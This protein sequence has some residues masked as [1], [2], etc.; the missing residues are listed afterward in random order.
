MT[1]HINRS[2]VT[3]YLRYN[4][5]QYEREY[6]LE[7]FRDGQGTIMDLQGAKISFDL[8]LFPN[9]LSPKAQENNYFKVLVVA[10]DEDPEAPNFN[11]DEISLSFFKKAEAIREVLPENNPEFGVW[12]SVVRSRQKSDEEESG[13]KFYELFNTDFDLIE[14]CVLGKTG[15]LK[16]TWQRSVATNETFTYAIDLGTSNTFMSRCKNDSNGQ[17]DLSK[18][19]ELFKMERPMVSFMHEIPD[20][21]QYSLTRR[22]EDSIFEKAKRKIKTEFLPAIIDGTD[23]RFPIRTAL[24]GI[25]N[26]AHKPKLFDNHNI[27]FFY[28]KIMAN[29]D[30]DVHTD[31]KWDKN[32]PLLRI[33][34]RELLLIIK[35]DIL[36]RNGDLDRTNLVWFSPLSFSGVERELYQDI[37]TKEPKNILFIHPDRI[38][39]YSESEAPYYYYVRKDYI[40]DSDAVSVIDIGGGSTDFVYFKDNKPQIASSV[41][42]GCDVL[43]ENGYNAFGNARE[44]GIYKKYADNLRFDRQDLEDLN[45]SFKH[46]DAVKTKDIIN[47]WLSNEQHCDIIKF[48]RT[49]F[50]S[51][52]VYH[53]TTILY[54]MANMYKDCGQMAPRTIVFSGN[55]SKYI[56]NFIASDSNVLKLVIDL[57]FDHVF[58]GKH[59]VNIKLPE[60]RK[61]ST[62]YGGLYRNPNAPRVKSVVYQGDKADN[63]NMVGDL[64]ANFESLKK[65]LMVKYKDLAGLYKSVLDKL[66]QEGMIDSTADTSKYIN[67]AA[68]DMGTP[69]TTYYK[70][71]VKEKYNEEVIY[72][73]SVFFLPIISRVFEMTNK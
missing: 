56:D 19:P 66:K 2:S 26:K 25:H 44:N 8:G 46:V 49:D 52:F 20:D 16:P 35:C 60:E 38:N 10:A 5:K 6:A 63:Y 51:V 62:C 42:F 12:P 67:A 50:K 7:P 72:N 43:W 39:Q 65:V 33:F 17:P 9:I 45:E 18:Q 30:Q 28:E 34:V 22:I 70:T 59:D 57:I 58:G 53:F 61:E 14:V 1:L 3:V 4:G 21:R 24:C 48:L 71:Q 55:G 15:L 23:Y 47:F 31:I 54:Y 11:I 13:T 41:H 36:Q 27:A 69:L 32:E 64:N 68:E 73:D 40:K 29:D 37:W